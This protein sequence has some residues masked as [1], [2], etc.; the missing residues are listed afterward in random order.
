MSLV[1]PPK[2]RSRDT[3][4]PPVPGPVSPLPA[5][6]WVCLNALFGPILGVSPRCSG[7]S[8]LCPTRDSYKRLSPRPLSSRSRRPISSKAPAPD[9]TTSS[10]APSLSWASAVCS[11][12]YL[13]A[14]LFHTVCGKVVRVIYLRTAFAPT[15]QVTD[16]S[17]FPVW[18][19]RRATGWRS[20]NRILLKTQHFPKPCPSGPCG[21]LPDSLSSAPATI[22]F[23]TSQSWRPRWP[24]GYGAR[25][26]SVDRSKSIA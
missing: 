17:Y 8:D 10:A 9:G 16:F 13:E 3:R 11:G 6:V 2:G 1:W 22:A 20:E 4:A 23:S 5:P 21:L 25:A 15:T 24:L 26:P 7:P 12:R 19:M 14:L 18:P